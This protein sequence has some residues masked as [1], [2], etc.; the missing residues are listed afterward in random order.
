M[1]ILTLLRELAPAAVPTHLSAW[2]GHT[3]GVD[4]MGWLHRS[5]YACAAELVRG[6]RDRTAPHPTAYLRWL[7]R[8]LHLCR[9]L[10]VH[11]IVVFDGAA[12]EAKRGTNDARDRVRLANRARADELWNAGQKEAAADLY[13]RCVSVS[14]RMRRNF[15]HLLRAEGVEFLFAPFEADAQLAQ[16]YLSGRISA[17][18]TEDSDLLAFGCERLLLKLDRAGNARLLS[19]R[20]VRDGAWDQKREPVLFKMKRILRAHRTDEELALTAVP[21]AAAALAASSA[22]AAAGPANVAAAASSAVPPVPSPACPPVRCEGHE[23]FLHACVLSGC[24]YLPSLH[25]IGLKKAVALVDEHRLLEPLLYHLRDARKRLEARWRA[26]KAKAA[27]SA[28][29]AKQMLE[30]NCDIDGSPS[31]EEEEAAVSAALEAAA[32]EGS[33]AGER[34]STAEY[35]AH[36]YRAVLT[37]QHQL[38]YDPATMSIT[39]LAPLPPQLQPLWEESLRA[40][41]AERKQQQQQ[42]AAVSDKE[43]L[44][45]DDDDSCEDSPNGTAGAL[46]AAFGGS[47]G[48]CFHS[49]AFPTFRDV[50]DATAAYERFAQR[51][52]VSDD[53]SP[54]S[55]WPPPL[56]PGHPLLA[57]RRF[58]F[59]GTPLPADVSTTDWTSGRINPKTMQPYAPGFRPTELPSASSTSAADAGSQ[60]LQKPGWRRQSSAIASAATA[61]SAAPARGALS[62][63][64]GRSTSASVSSPFTF[65]SSSSSSSAAPFSAPRKLFS[66]VPSKATL[67]ASRKQAAAAVDDLDDFF[68]AGEDD[69]SDAALREMA[70]RDAALDDV[71]DADG[72]DGIA[73][74]IARQDAAAAS[75]AAAVAADSAATQPLD[76]AMQLDSAATEGSPSLPAASAA[77]SSAIASPVLN[78]F[79][80]PLR[81]VDDVATF[82]DALETTTGADSSMLQGARPTSHHSNGVAKLSATAA[83]SSSSSSLRLTSAPPPSASTLLSK[84]FGTPARIAPAAAASTATASIAAASAAA[85]SSSQSAIRVS[86]LTSLVS[87]V[88]KRASALSASSPSPVSAM[89]AVVSVADLC[90]LTDD[91]DGDADKPASVMVGTKSVRLNGVSASAAAASSVSRTAAASV[92]AAASS[93]VLK[94][95]ASAPPSSA[96]Q[97]QPHPP[98][99][100]SSVPVRRTSPIK[101]QKSSPALPHGA[102]PTGA[103]TLHSFFG[104]KS[105]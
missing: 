17:A 62:N 84:L 98:P 75:G 94:R 27:K 70:M 40:V 44:L 20:A 4:A 23:R 9:A 95:K 32:G 55:R 34:M 97:Q 50:T 100:A 78:P 51:G 28:L 24:D 82:A 48:G 63:F 6:E 7:Q 79:A 52:F 25:G 11:L 30:G 22:A 90:D 104:R 31:Q 59:M 102:V 35:I 18:I 43:V 37:F 93:P 21:P 41:A 71:D 73:A 85:V 14:A 77:A 54:E 2:S 101:R 67:L 92:S 38:V 103:A 5:A 68:G 56:P 8:M 3:L 60:Q 29:A 15:V 49:A 13:A 16:L 69:E 88:A 45:L 81:A 96:P 64:F 42:H 87:P 76:D 58:D 1:G 47:A 89:A 86:P 10:G 36:F 105:A 12:L 61:S 33:T 53:S 46:S 80:L 99:S 39:H 26:D 74:E 72:G 66:L 65:S 91:A 83:T 19:L 57:L